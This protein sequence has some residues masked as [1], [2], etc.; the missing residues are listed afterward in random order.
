MSI[1][2]D[3]HLNYLDALIQ[4]RNQAMQS[5]NFIVALMN[6]APE[7]T[8]PEVLRAFNEA[9]MTLRQQDWVISKLAEAV[10]DYEERIQALA[11]K[12]NPTTK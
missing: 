2:S 11:D 6:T 4:L 5:H 9:R 8:P 12:V 7:G 1:N 3:F 10:E